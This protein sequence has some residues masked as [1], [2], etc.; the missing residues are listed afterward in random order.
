MNKAKIDKPG[1]LFTKPLSTFLG[2]TLND[3]FKRQGFAS[4][5]A[6][7]ALGRDRRD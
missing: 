5:G 2:A 3:V 7:H 6:R 4:R 1:P